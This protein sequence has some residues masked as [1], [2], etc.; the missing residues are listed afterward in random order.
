MHSNESHRVILANSAS[1][2]YSKCIEEIEYIK[3]GIYNNRKGTTELTQITLDS[4]KLQ[5][6]IQREGLP[7]AQA[8]ERINGVPNFQDVFIIEKILRM[9][10]SICRITVTSPYGASG[11]GTGFLIAPGILITNHHVLDSVETAAGSFVQFNYQLSENRSALS[12]ITFRLR[13]DLFFATSSLEKTEDPFSGLD[14]SF[15]AVENLSAEGVSIDVIDHARLD[16]QLGKVLEGENCVVIQH[17][18][19]DFKKIVLKDI[20][21]ITLVDDF[22]VYESDTLPGSSG[23]AVIGLGTGEVVALHHSGVPRRNSQGDWLRKDGTPVQPGDPDHLIDWIGNEG[24]RVS[25][26]VKAL[27]NMPLPAAMENG[28]A[29]ILGAMQSKTPVTTTPKSEKNMQP[30]VTPT[31]MPVA[32]LPPNR[33]YFEVELI[34]EDSLQNDFLANTSKYIPGIRNKE[35]LFPYST[36]PDQRNLYYLEVQSATNPWELAQ[37]IEALPHIVSCTPDLPMATDIGVSKEDQLLLP[38]E[39]AVKDAVY[40]DGTATWNEKEF[41]A[42]WSNSVCYKNAVALRPDY[43]RQ[44]NWVAVNMHKV[45][46]TQE[47]KNN[48]TG[49]K[50]TQ[51]DT[52]YSDHSKVKAGYDLQ[53]DMDFIDNDTDARDTQAGFGLKQPNHGTRTASLVVGGKISQGSFLHDGNRGILTE[54]DQPLV[55]L[56][57]YRVSK[58]VVLIGRGKDMVAAA[59]HAISNGTDVMY[60]CMG[61]YPRPMIEAV[62]RLAYDKGVIW[63]CA[64]GNEVEMVIAPAL[65]PGTIAVAAINPDLKPWNGSS[66]GPAVDIAAPGEAVYVPFWDK[67]KNENMCYGN[68]TSY[69]TPHVAAAAMLWK[70]KHKEA[71]AKYT[72][73]WQVVEAFRLCLKKSC[74]KPDG[75]TAN[76]SK[77]FG[78]GILDVDKLL[79]DETVLPEVHE[80]RYAYSGRGSKPQWDLGVR[81]SVHFLWNTLRRKLRPGNEEAAMAALPLSRRGQIALSALAESHPTTT[82]SLAAAGKGAEKT[83]LAEYFRSH[84]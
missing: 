44:W 72:Q 26:I 9:S 22:L 20:R 67:N 76:Y 51:L 71:L 65:Y 61:S 79:S 59:H 82:E 32:S 12:P 40:D 62:A 78:E 58:S 15:V 7:V 24:I 68:G 66:N 46:L 34:D 63:V 33:L 13:P 18:G 70:A 64:A 75:W 36:L 69:A 81:E 30:P 77:K 1:L 57:P 17:P 4:D 42:S 55:R 54:N 14:F 45:S 80:L 2:R 27:R 25:S 16:E 56:I 47:I 74:S 23:S 41:Q 39:S 19:G 49:L 31:P 53:L 38:T 83:F 6:R 11:Y 29:L 73:P 8:L 50:L 48:L 28:R 84:Q 3:K 60:M 21:M 10:R 37:E 52:G 43:Y 35:R 5:K